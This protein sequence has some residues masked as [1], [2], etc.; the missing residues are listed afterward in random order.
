MNKLEACISCP[1]SK[2]IIIPIKVKELYIVS[3]ENR[4]L[5]IIIK[6]IYINRYKPLPLF[7]I[8]P[9]KKIIDN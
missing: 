2:Y 4:K 1:T 6:T 9:R 3:P 7:I 8:I 5:V